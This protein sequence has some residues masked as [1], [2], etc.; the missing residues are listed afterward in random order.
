MRKLGIVLIV[1]IALVIVVIVAIPLVV[2]VNRYHGLVKSQLSKD[3][4]RQVSF[5]AMHL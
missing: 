5:G 2:D 3:L 1:I 4:C